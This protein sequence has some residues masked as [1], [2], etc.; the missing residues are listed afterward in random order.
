MEALDQVEEATKEVEKDEDQAGIRLSPKR[1]LSGAQPY[2]RF[3]SQEEDE[4]LEK[5][6][7]VGME[8]KRSLWFETRH[9]PRRV[10]S[11]RSFIDKKFGDKPRG[12][13]RQRASRDSTVS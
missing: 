3:G 10:Q 11:I 8:E 2:L 6:A 7:S 4:A 1:S 12:S 5:D 9:V 13:R